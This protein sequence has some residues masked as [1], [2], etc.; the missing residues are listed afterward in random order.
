M[1]KFNT[2]QQI[3]ENTIIDQ[4]ILETALNAQGDPTISVSQF[5]GA[6]VVDPNLGNYVVI[7]FTV[8][9]TAAMNIGRIRLMHGQTPVAISEDKQL[10]IVKEANKNLKIRLAAQFAGA[11]NCKFNTTSV[12]LPYATPFREG[13]VRFNNGE[14]VNKSGTVYSA[15]DVDAKIDAV[16]ES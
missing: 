1:L 16:T 3:A 13:V 15:A 14:E 2:P 12:N 10:L 5:K 9:D 6:V 8:T 7:D 4:I 11:E